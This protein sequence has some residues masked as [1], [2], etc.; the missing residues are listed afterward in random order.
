MKLRRP[1]IAEQRL[2]K[3]LASKATSLNLPDNWL[4]TLQV[5]DMADGGMGSLQLFPNAVTKENRI[6]GKTVSEYQFTDVDNT[7]VLVSLNV[8]QGGELFELDIWK[9]DFSKLI[10]IPE[11]IQ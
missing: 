9:T 1:T 3:A 2:L 6:F 7:Q 8:D 11:I 10:Q 4:T 5:Q